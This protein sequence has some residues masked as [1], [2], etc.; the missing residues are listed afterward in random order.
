M[1]CSQQ[2]GALVP[3]ALASKRLRKISI[4][5][6][7]VTG[8]V[9]KSKEN[10]N[11][12]M[13]YE[14]CLV[15]FLQPSNKEVSKAAKKAHKEGKNQPHPHRSTEGSVSVLSPGYGGGSVGG[16]DETSV[17][18]GAIPNEYR[19]GGTKADYFAEPDFD[20][21]WDTKYKF[22]ISC[23]SIKGTSK[24]GVFLNIELGPIKQTRQL[25]FKSKEE[26]EDFCSVVEH[27]L[28]LEKERG[29]AK[30][31]VAFAGKAL[32]KEEVTFLLEIVSAW[33]LPAG[34]LFSSDPYVMVMSGG[35]EIHRTK[36]LAKT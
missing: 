34:D 30:L 1:L 4:E 17:L 24:A 11:S 3:K 23:M 33:N 12:D 36:Y 27:E 7:R 31:R 9:A 21:G 22:P 32:P 14:E 20:K 35:K 28:K 18:D 10:N 13:S 26:A 6:H 29:E 8:A 19:G 15:R 16:Q 5:V 2:Q 25:I